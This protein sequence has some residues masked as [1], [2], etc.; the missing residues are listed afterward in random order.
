MLSSHFFAVLISSAN[1]TFLTRQTSISKLIYLFLVVEIIVQREAR[2]SSYTSLTDFLEAIGVW[3]DEL[4]INQLLGAP[5]F[6]LM[7]DECTDIAT[8]LKSCP[9]LSLSRK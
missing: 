5:F 2:N 9:F 8:I 7:A 3:I 1:N 4:R 6:T